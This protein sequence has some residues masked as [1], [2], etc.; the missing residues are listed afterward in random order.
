MTP[1]R[2][3][4]HQIMNLADRTNCATLRTWM[5]ATTVL[6]IYIVLLV[7]GGAAGYLKAKSRVS[8][9]TSLGSAAVLILCATR[10]I[11]PLVADLL[12]GLLIVVFAMRFAKTRKFMPAGLMLA[13]TAL[14][15]VARWLLANPGV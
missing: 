6:W 7:A 12:M 3:C 8:L 4:R 10:V 5:N 11:P 13:L 14:A 9:Y 2:A 15:L 1:G